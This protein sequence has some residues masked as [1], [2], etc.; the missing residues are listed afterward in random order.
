MNPTTHERAVGLA[1]AELEGHDAPALVAD[2]GAMRDDQAPEDGVAECCVDHK[3]HDASAGDLPLIKHGRIVDEDPRT[4]G[5]TSVL[6]PLR[7]AER[8][9]ASSPAG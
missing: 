1:V 4:H 5:Q 2:L 3:R 8:S 7:R 9:Q 6:A